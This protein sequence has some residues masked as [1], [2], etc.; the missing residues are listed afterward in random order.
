MAKNIDL[1]LA[2]IDCCSYH[3]KIFLD[4]VEKQFT[5]YDRIESDRKVIQ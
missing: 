2:L 3:F 5:R 1:I 4:N